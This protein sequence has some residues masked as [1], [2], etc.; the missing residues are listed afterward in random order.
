MAGMKVAKETTFDRS[1]H[2]TSRTHFCSRARLTHAE[3]K[4]SGGASLYAYEYNYDRV[5]NRTSLVANGTPTYTTYNAAN[6][7]LQEVTPGVETAYPAFLTSSGR[8]GVVGH[9]AP[10]LL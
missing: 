6:E 2:L 9:P 5:G 10:A 8:Q 7:L 1:E 3:W 4:P